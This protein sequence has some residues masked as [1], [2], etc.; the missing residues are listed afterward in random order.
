MNG[1]LVSLRCCDFQPELH[2]LQQ[3]DPCGYEGFRDCYL[4]PRRHGRHLGKCSFDLLESFDVM[5]I[6]FD[7]SILV[8]KEAR[9]CQGLF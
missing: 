6:E 3:T 8:W 1:D 9:I 7:S 2:S 4:E 5:E